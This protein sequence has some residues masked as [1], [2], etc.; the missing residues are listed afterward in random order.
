MIAEK[1]AA[2]VL[3]NVETEVDKLAT[4]DET[5]NTV[6]DTLEIFEVIAE[7]LTSSAGV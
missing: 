7:T 3:V 1:E 4:V 6:V 5:E 2:T